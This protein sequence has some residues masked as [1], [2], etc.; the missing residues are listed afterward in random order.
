MQSI[1][2]TTNTNPQRRT[3]I[4]SRWFSTH[5]YSSTVSSGVCV[6]ECC[7]ENQLI[8]LF[9]LSFFF[10]IS[11]FLRKRCAIFIFVQFV[12][13]DWQWTNRCLRCARQYNR[14][15]F[16]PIAYTAH[17]RHSRFALT[18][19]HATLHE[20]LTHTLGFRIG[21]SVTAVAVGSAAAAWLS[22][23]LNRTH[24]HTHAHLTFD[25]VTQRPSTQL[26]FI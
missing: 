11:Y 1:R 20:M 8:L 21:L 19:T 7:F 22:V 25:C 12:D 17:Y 5:N 4:S 2:G 6:C 26:S 15:R 16:S 13:K 10:I 23:W 24:T 9:F 14:S 18:Q 3:L